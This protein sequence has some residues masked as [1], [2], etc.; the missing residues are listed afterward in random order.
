MLLRLFFTPDKK[1]GF[2]RQTGQEI[3][4]YDINAPVKKKGKKS[5]KV[6]WLEQFKQYNFMYKD[7]EIPELSLLNLGGIETLLISD[8]TNL[9]YTKT[10]PQM[11]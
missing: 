5:A 6:K 10:F 11:Q 2:V 4:L 9:I 1:T 7:A 8:G 3:T